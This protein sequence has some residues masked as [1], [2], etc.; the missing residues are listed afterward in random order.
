MQAEVLVV[1]ELEVW[2]GEQAVA[3][4]AEMPVA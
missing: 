3:W 4:L 2:I 1:G